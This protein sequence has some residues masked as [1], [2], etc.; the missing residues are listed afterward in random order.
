MLLLLYPY[1]LYEILF[2]ILQI[3]IYHTFYFIVNTSENLQT[4]GKVIVASGFFPG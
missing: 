3:I 4:F 1:Y 2:S